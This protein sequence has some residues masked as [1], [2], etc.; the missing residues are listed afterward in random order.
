MKQIIKGVYLP[1]FMNELAVPE[2]AECAGLLMN[3]LWVQQHYKL[4]DATAFASE[5]ERLNQTFP[6]NMY[7]AFNDAFLKVTR[8]SYASIGDANYLQAVIDR[9]YYTEL[10]KI[11]VDGLNIRHQ[12]RVLNA[13]DSVYNDPKIREACINRIKAIVDITDETMQNSLKL[14]E[15]FIENNDIEFAMKTLEPW[16]DEG[17]NENLLFTYVSLC[18]TDEFK[19]QT[20][21]FTNAMLR[22]QELNP[23]RFCELFNG[24]YF[25]LRVFENDKVKA[26]YCEHCSP[27]GRMAAGE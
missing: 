25:S 24:D 10:R 12:F 13:A 1:T 14:A 23:G 5:V 19:M 9:L 22:A 26:S 15:L 2:K 16:V 21:R 17:T 18:S 8:G 20:Q 4:I 6:G 3:K 27:T 7:I 11:T